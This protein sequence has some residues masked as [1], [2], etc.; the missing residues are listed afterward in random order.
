MGWIIQPRK[1]PDI[2]R[3]DKNTDSNIA[4]CENYTIR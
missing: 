4:V 3:C 2:D 1:T